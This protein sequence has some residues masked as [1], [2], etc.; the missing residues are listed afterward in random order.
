MS[1]Q[2]AVDGAVLEVIS[3]REIVRLLHFTTNRGLLGIIATGAIKS[4]ASLEEDQ[5]VEYLFT[6]NAET[7]KDP[8]W[9][10]HVS[11]SVSR[12]NTSFLSYSRA[13]HLTKDLWWCVL[14]IEPEI[15]GHEGVRFCTI[16]NIWPSV[17]RGTSSHGLEA[18]FAEVVIGRYQAKVHRDESM[19]DRWP[20]ELQAEV[21]YPGEISTDYVQCIY[22]NDSMHSA[23]AE[24]YVT[25]VGHRD[26]DIVLDPATFSVGEPSR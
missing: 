4:R 5:Y 6:P 11:L 2:I 26:V 12:T 23:V 19:L 13:S 9:A 14:A 24:S 10:G 17:S 3:R 22:V 25:A 21:L 18:M 15:L 16:N 1:G 8:R 20:T 7:R